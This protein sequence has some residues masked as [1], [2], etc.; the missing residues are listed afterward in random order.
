MAG[1][2]PGDRLIL[3][4]PLGTGILAFASQ[5]GRA[6]AGSLEAAARSMAALNNAASKV[7]IE[8]Q[9]HAATDVTGFGLMGHL[10]AMAAASKVDVEIIWDALPLLPGVLECLADGIASGAVERNR[11]SSGDCL[12]A[13]PGVQ[14]EMLDLC[15]DPQTSGGLLIAIG[16]DKAGSLLEELHA[17]GVADAMIVGKVLHSGS[18]KVFIRT[19]GRRKLPSP[20]PLPRESGNAAGNELDEN[21]PLNRETI[22]MDC[23]QGNH[24]TETNAASDAGGTAQTERKFQEFLESAASPGALDGKTKRAIAIALSVL[25]KCEPCVKSNVKKAR[26]MGFSQE[27]ID[28][29]AWLGIAFGGSPAMAFYKR[30]NH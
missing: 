10:G 12:I 29:A 25:A 8:L 15:F 21:Q 17:A 18:G 5:I 26:D 20:R 30:V 9:A 3:T 4:K 13:E 14:P 11:E 24:A 22:N 1:A 16:E 19:N 6:P 23:C 28:E 7:M 27:E 2:K